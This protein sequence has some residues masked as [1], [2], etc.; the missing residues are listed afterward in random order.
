MLPGRVVM[1]CH[2]RCVSFL[3]PLVVFVRV[4]RGD[5]NVYNSNISSE[6]P[7]ESRFEKILFSV[8]KQ[9]VPMEEGGERHASLLKVY[10]G[11]IGPPFVPQE[12]VPLKRMDSKLLR[13][14]GD[15]RRRVSRDWLKH[16]TRRQCST[17]R[18]HRST[19]SFLPGKSWN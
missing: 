7:R 11:E 12:C 8:R 14:P 17:G 3:H 18:I 16:Q 13:K 6:K 1:S 19:T 5:K 10:F 2:V 4:T 15:K 9:G